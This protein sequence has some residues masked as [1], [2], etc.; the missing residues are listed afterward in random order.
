M[1]KE[2]REASRAVGQTITG[3]VSREPLWRASRAVGQ[4]RT[5]SLLEASVAY[6]EERGLLQLFLSAAPGGV[7]H[8]RSVLRLVQWSALFPGGVARGRSGIA[9]Q[10]KEEQYP[11]G[12]SSAGR[13]RPRW[14]RRHSGRRLPCW[15]GLGKG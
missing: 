5:G 8:G 1:R 11:G 2:D 14:Y 6:G 3:I 9:A 15:S 10:N 4:P 13:Q 7:A 12:V